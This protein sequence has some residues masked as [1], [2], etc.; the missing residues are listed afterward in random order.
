MLDFGMRITKCGVMNA[1]LD[2]GY[3]VMKILITGKPGIG[4]TTVI[5]TVATKLKAAVNDILLRGFIT[6]E[7][8]EGGRRIGFGIEDWEGGK[9]TLS[10]VES[11][12]VCRVGRYGVEIE[13]FEKI[14]IPSLEIPKEGQKVLYLIDEIG[15]MECFSESFY[16]AIRE[17]FEGDYPVVSTIAMGGHP[18]IREIKSRPDITVI[19]LDTKNRE[20]VP[21]KIVD[22][23]LRKFR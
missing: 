20:M 15:K 9:G 17:I 7:K 21:E 18:F 14:A 16:R 12:S 10:H 19:R 3:K 1:E 22:T 4:K 5:R 6:E 2:A 8:R 13:A 11:K 23:I